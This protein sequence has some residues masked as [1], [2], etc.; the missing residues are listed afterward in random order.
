MFFYENYFFCMFLHMS[1]SV[2]CFV[3]TPYFSILDKYRLEDFEYLKANLGNLHSE[4]KVCPH[5]F[6]GIVLFS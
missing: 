6:E 5:I 2:H 1:Y 4:D 3:L